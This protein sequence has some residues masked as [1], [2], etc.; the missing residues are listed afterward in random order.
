MA[1]GTLSNETEQIPLNKQKVEARGIRHE[2]RRRRQRFQ[3]NEV[4]VHRL[5][6]RLEILPA[7]F[8]CLRLRCPPLRCLGMSR[9]AR[10]R[11]QICTECCYEFLV[12]RISGGPEA[13]HRV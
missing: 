9:C 11:L 2:Y 4:P 10:Q 6:G 7:C 8:P 13:E 12:F 3:P 1:K 5:S